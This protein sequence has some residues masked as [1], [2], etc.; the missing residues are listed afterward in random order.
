[1]VNVNLYYADVRGID[2]SNALYPP[3]SKSKGSAFGVSLL[4]EAYLDC[5]GKKLPKLI[6]L[7]SGQ[8]MFSDESE[9]HFSISHSKTHVM[10]ALS[11]KP[12]GVDTETHRFMKQSIIER[13]TSPAELASLSF[14]DIWVLR[15]SLYKLTGEGDLRTMRFYR[16]GGRIISPNES[17]LCRLYSDI[18]DSSAAVACYAGDFP[19]HITKIPVEKLLKKEHR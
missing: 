16:R 17:A 11:D 10:C 13:L 2:E 7:L 9:L 4:A 14:F 19:D 6:K 15:E 1:M 8:A 3:L 5:T 12:V 18:E